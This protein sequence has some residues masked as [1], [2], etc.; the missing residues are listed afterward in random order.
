M[1][2]ERACRGISDLLGDPA[3]GGE[4]TSY[5]TEQL[6]ACEFESLTC[7]VLLAVARCKKEH[8]SVEPSA[9]TL[10][11]AIASPSLLSWILLRDIDA[12]Y[13]E[14]LA[15]SLRHSGSAPA[16]FQANPFFGK[17]VRSFLPPAY[18]LS[19][20]ALVGPVTDAFRIQWAYEWDRLIVAKGAELTIRPMDYW[21]GRLPGDE[22]YVSVDTQMS[23]IYR[24]AFLR[25]LAWGLSGGLIREPLAVHLAAAALPLDLELWRVTP[26]RRPDWWPTAE[27]SAG[28]LDTIPG[29]AWAMVEQLWERQQ[30]C[31]SWAGQ[32]GLGESSILAHASGRVSSGD[33]VYDL[34]IKGVFQKTHGPAI[35]D[36]SD[37]ADWLR[38]NRDDAVGSLPSPVRF[39]GA[40]GRADPDAWA[41]DFQDWS[42]LPSFGFG[43]T[44]PTPR[45]QF[46]R[47]W[48]EIQ[49]PAPYLLSPGATF[50]ATED[51]IEIVDP[52][53]GLVARWS[54]WTDGLSEKLVDDLPPSTGCALAV[55]R[56][57]IEE[58][59]QRYRSRF[60][61]VSTL[62]T[63]TRS[64]THDPYDS[65]RD[66]RIFGGTRLVGA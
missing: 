50:G 46:W 60:C 13:A 66:S 25:T 19:I 37:I 27:A 61:W 44:G 22:R 17:Y 57:V 24:S 8:N 52:K 45:W 7:H 32:S 36:A 65:F 12:S 58:F 20:E 54:D 33:S 23:E 49:L 3:T 16:D 5:L 56:D 38:T 1:V 9:Q 10:S 59:E 30:R 55:E 6:R 51:R 40:I 64:S 4:T 62:T 29:E 15:S 18:D 26:K 14:P 53:L 11:D 42:I 28:V 35:P 47:F 41:R 63:F 34:S 43:R 48:R 2:R 21:L 39:A 31:E